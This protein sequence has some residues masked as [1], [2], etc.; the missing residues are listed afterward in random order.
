[1]FPLN[2]FDENSKETYVGYRESGFFPEAFVNMLAM[3]GWNPGTTQEIFSLDELVEAFSFERV[4]KSGAKFDPEKTKWFNQQYLRAKSDKELAALFTPI[5]KEHNI[6]AEPAFVEGVC[7]LVKE[8]AHF[9]SEFW[10]NGSYFFIA[11]TTYDADVIKKRWNENS[12]DFIKAVAADFKALSTFTAAETEATF[13]ATA[14]KLGT[15]TGEVMQLFRAC[16]SGVGGGPMLFEMVEL[17]GKE[18]VI[19]RLDEASKSLSS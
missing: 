8:K 6:V 15:K 3:L 9:V 18:E 17:L 14:E 5:L 1:M 12:A 10:T 2:W 16:L 11:P 19:K 4:N 13:K 7:K